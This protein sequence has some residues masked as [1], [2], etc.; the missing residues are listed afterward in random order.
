MDRGQYHYPFLVNMG[1]NHLF[2]QD[3]EIIN[4]K[5]LNNCYGLSFG[6][7][8]AIYPEQSYTLT[9]KNFV[10]TNGENMIFLSVFNNTQQK[11]VLAPI[12][13][14]DHYYMENGVLDLQ[15]KES[16]KL[17]G[18]DFIIN[19]IG[20]KQYAFYATYFDLRIWENGK[21]SESA[22]CFEAGKT[23]AP[24]CTEKGYTTYTC[25]LCG[26]S[27]K[28]DYTAALGHSLGEWET[29]TAPTAEN[30]GEE[31]RKCKNCDHSESRVI[32]ALGYTL[33]D[34]NLD[35]SVDVMDA[36]FIRLIVAKLVEPTAKQI[37][38]GDV[39]LDGKITAI[40]ANIIRKYVIGIIKEL[41]VA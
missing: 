18:K 22:S 33:S 21:D 9:L 36:Y 23:T 4:G 39:D 24:T 27:K 7:Y 29:V 20:N 8:F 25:S 15:S 32:P 1:K 31:Q 28:A 34:V 5:R 26:Y 10:E 12:P 14:D 16:E 13:M 2:F 19:Y 17:S 6:N 11:T 40:D 30:P 38:M 41:P 35:G 37:E 3:Y